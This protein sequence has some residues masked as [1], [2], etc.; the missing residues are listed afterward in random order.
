MSKLN[1]SIENFGNPTQT[2]EC[3]DITMPSLDESTCSPDNIISIADFSTKRAT[4][5]KKYQGKFDTLKDN[6]KKKCLLTNIA[7]LI[8]KN[9]KEVNKWNNEIVTLKATIDS[10]DEE[11]KTNEENIQKNEG[12]KLIKE[13]RLISSGENKN[14][15]NK[16]FIIYIVLIVLFLVIQICLIVF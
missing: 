7:N 14:A 9:K 4:L 3:N 16:E 15:I 2:H 12:Y 8:E 13:N 6:A 11:I 10:N 5:L 1:Y